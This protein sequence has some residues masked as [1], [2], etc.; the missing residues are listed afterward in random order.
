MRAIEDVKADALFAQ[1]EARLTNEVANDIASAAP[2][3]PLSLDALTDHVRQT[4]QR[5]DKLSAEELIWHPPDDMDDLK[6]RKLNAELDLMLFQ[7][8]GLQQDEAVARA[9]DHV[10]KEAGVTLTDTEVVA[11]FAEIVRRGMV[12]LA[13]RKIDRYE[14]RH[15]RPFHDHLFD[16]ARP[17]SVTFGELAEIFLAERRAEYAANAVSK[18]REDKIEATLATLREIIGD[19][20]PVAS[21]DD[22]VVQKLRLTVE[23]LPANR[24]KIYAGVPLPEQIARADKEG[25]RRL[26]HLTQRGYL[27]TMRD[28]LTVAVRKKHL[29]SNPAADL[30]PLK[31]DDTA[32]AQKRLPLTLEQIKGFFTG[33]FYRSCAPDAAKPYAKTDRDWRFWL[34]LIML[35][36][37][38]RPE[39]ICQLH[40][41]DVRQTDAGTWYLDI[42]GDNSAEGGKSLKTTTSRRRIPVHPELVR[43]GF[44]AFVERRRK[45]GDKSLFSGLTANTY[46]GLSWYPTRRLNEL[47]MPAEIIMDKRQ[48]LY[49]LRHS[50]R[51]ALRRSKAPPEALLHIGGWSQ[52]KLVSDHYGDG[53]H[54]DLMAEHVAA[55]SY[56]GLDLTFLHPTDGE[57]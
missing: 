8:P 52:G 20:T 57:Q 45:T 41:A 26:S 17:S 43:I 51:D 44:L 35:F 50:L 30:K 38:A 2:L 14:D 27:D 23:R 1:A 42:V 53:G 24:N 12:E 18:K 6:E 4:V 34:P 47:F 3:A 33:S 16:P 5:R 7:R 22:D 11:G 15:E 56:P 36:S 9:T 32:T 21:I 28:V 54:P 31:K 25:R 49:S 37:G 48:S 55:I 10:L 13:R 40:V 29:P 39:E 19:M 46:G